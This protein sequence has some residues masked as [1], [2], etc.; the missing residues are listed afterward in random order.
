MTELS[1]Y[2]G[3]DVDLPGTGDGCGPPEIGY[4]CVI[5]LVLS[6]HRLTSYRS[7]LLLAYHWDR[8]G[9]YKRI[10]QHCGQLGKGLLWGGSPA[11][12]HAQVRA[13]SSPPHLPVLLVRIQT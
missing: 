4:M 5:T 13:I 12:V 1:K 6:L 9:Q 8:Y 2:I 11:Y 3:N 10:N 7:R